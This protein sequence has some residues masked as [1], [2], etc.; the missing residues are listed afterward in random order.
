VKILLIHADSF[1]YEVK[2]R[3]IKTPE[4][5]PEEMKALSLEDVLVAFCTVEKE[6]AHDPPQIAQKASDSIAEVAKWVKTKK[7]VVYPYAHLSSSLASADFSVPL[8]ARMQEILSGMGFE[9]R[10]SPF[11]WYKAFSIKC[12]GH[13]LSELSRTISAE[14][15]KEERKPQPQV[16]EDSAIFTPDGRIYGLREYDYGPDE[17]DFRTLVEREGLKIP[18]AET[19]EEP[20]YIAYLKKFGIEAEPLSDIGNMRYGPRGALIFDLIGDYSLELALALNALPIKGAN[21]FDLDHP[22]IKAHAQL[23]GERLYE[24]DLDDKRY[25]LRYAACFQQF[26]MLKD[27]TLSYRNLPL[28]VFELADSYRLEQPGEVV[29]LFRTRKFLMPDL[30]YF[31]RDLP[32]SQ[33]QFIE[34][35]K[36]ILEEARK[37]G[38]SYVSLYNLTRSF[39]EEN[40][41]FVRTLAEIEGKPILVHFVPEKKYY[42]VINIEYHIVDVL[43]RPREIATCQIDVGNAERFGIKYADVDGSTRHPPILHIAILGSVER[44]LYGILDSAIKAEERGEVP[45]LPFWL[46]PIQVRI[47]PVTDAF[48]NDA[49]KIAQTVKSQKVRVDVDD[50]QETV[51]KKV[52]DAETQWVPYII[53]VGEREAKTGSLPVRIR[54]LRGEIRE[55]KM[56]ELVCELKKEQGDKPFRQSYLPMLV[57]SRPTDA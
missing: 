45:A 37:S 53:V 31:C 19:R 5:V 1:A 8:L 23:F 29:S 49:L 17:G 51:Q 9:V 57:S 6:D 24:V 46:C 43:G 54:R 3:A 12:K 33:K 28:G 34:I 27:W 55:M 52:R 50:T 26:A 22:A 36:L 14:P 18:H 38:W 7:I 35:H 21:M 48:L 15:R 10:R 11:G 47:I 39:L 4:A 2:D 32:D 41:E 20:K 56:E 16:P 40:R 42:W 44:Y 30:H 25:V 13:P